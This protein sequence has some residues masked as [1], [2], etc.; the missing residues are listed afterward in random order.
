M[1]VASQP[2]S[3]QANTMKNRLTS[4]LMLG[5]LLA[6]PACDEENEDAGDAGTDES[7][8]S[9]GDDML[10]PPPDDDMTETG[11]TGDDDFG[12]GEDDGTTGDET[13][14]LPEDTGDTGE[15]G[16]DDGG[17]LG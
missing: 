11:T 4:I 8:E 5:A 2:G 16:D 9:T 10:G 13:I 15:S 12:P 6:L 17:I 7:G 1:S 3:S 14:G